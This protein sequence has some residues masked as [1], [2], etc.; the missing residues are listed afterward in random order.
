MSDLWLRQYGTTSWP[1]VSW[2]GLRS[3][4]FAQLD[5]SKNV[6]RKQAS[7]HHQVVG[8]LYVNYVQKNHFALVRI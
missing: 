2:G 3:V 4:W 6:L 5:T 7:H 8:E 1:N